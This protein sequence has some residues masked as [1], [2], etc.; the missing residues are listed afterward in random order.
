MYFSLEKAQKLSLELN[1]K[2]VSSE[3]SFGANSRFFLLF[4]FQYSF[5]IYYTYN[6]LKKE[7]NADF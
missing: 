3:V 2:N 7:R 5:T 4:D 6:S 1:I